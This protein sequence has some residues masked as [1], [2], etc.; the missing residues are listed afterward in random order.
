MYQR[1]SQELNTG[2]MLQNHNQR[3]LEMRHASSGAE[4]CR[5]EEGESWLRCSSEVVSEKCD[6]STLKQLREVHL[7]NTPDRL[8][9]YTASE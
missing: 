3:L 4:R 6:C 5:R 2:K 7:T 1:Q 8:A 9:V